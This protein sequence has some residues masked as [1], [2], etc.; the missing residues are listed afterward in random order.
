VLGYLLAAVSING[1]NGGSGGAG[2]GTGTAGSGGYGG[3][4]GS[5]LYVCFGKNILTVGATDKVMGS[6]SG[7]V[8]GPGATGDF[9]L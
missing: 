7:S 8:G 2:S 9:T 4:I 6:P 3:S 5:F 1:G